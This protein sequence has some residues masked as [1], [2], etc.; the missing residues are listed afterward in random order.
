[1]IDDSPEE[2][3]SWSKRLADSASRYLILKSETVRGGLDV[4]QDQKVVCVVLDLDMGDSSGFEVLL[5][6]IPDRKRPEMATVVL[7]HLQNPPLRDA[8]L[9][10]GAQAYLVKQ[11]ASAQDLDH[12]IQQAIVSVDSS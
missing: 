4:C 6:L 10:H 5:H 1:M 2:L 3:Q 11:S 7:T 12:A 8:A 9:Y